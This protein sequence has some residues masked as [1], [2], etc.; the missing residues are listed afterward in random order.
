MDEQRTIISSNTKRMVKLHGI[1]NT[2]SKFQKQ[3][4]EFYHLYQIT[5]KQ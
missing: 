5:I 4:N 2:M 1:I 3:Y